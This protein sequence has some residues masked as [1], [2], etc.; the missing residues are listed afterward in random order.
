[1]PRNAA[2][3]RPFMSARPSSARSQLS[4][5]AMAWIALGFGIWLTAGLVLVLWAI[6][7]DLA[8]H[9][10]ASIY[11][12]PVYLGLIALCVYSAV[13]LVRALRSGRGWRGAFPRGYGL[14]GA[15]AA[16]AI[17][18]LVAELGWR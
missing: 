11:H 7:Q 16:L 13:R 18:A 12:V 17:V 2:R 8:D 14:L 3:M 1:M 4:D 10:F 6:D 15:G 5:H 9:P